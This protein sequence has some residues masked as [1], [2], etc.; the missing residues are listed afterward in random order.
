[1]VIRRRARLALAAGALAFSG[2]G[3]GDAPFGPTGPAATLSIAAEFA[4]GSAE[5]AL[6]A[7]QV[8]R[9][10]VLFVRSDQHVAVDETVNWPGDALTL[11]LGP[12]RLPLRAESDQF[13]VTVTGYLGTQAAFIFGPQTVTVS[14][15]QTTSVDALL[16]YV[17]VSFGE[18]AV[19]VTGAMQLSARWFGA[20]LTVQHLDQAAWDYSWIVG[21]SQAA[22]PFLVVSVP[23]HF[24]AGSYA[25]TT[26]DLLRIYG[27]DDSVY[28]EAP[29][30][31]LIV[32]AFEDQS[33]YTEVL[34]VTTG[35]SLTV[36]SVTAPSST[37]PGRV[38]GT[39]SMQA[40]RYSVRYA[41]EGG[42]D[43]TQ[44]T[45][46]IS[47]AGAFDLPFDFEVEGTSSATVT[48]GPFPGTYRGGGYVG[49]YIG[50]TV[51]YTWGYDGQNAELFTHFMIA[52]TTPGAY[53]IPDRVELRIS[54]WDATTDAYGDA[55]GGTLELLELVPPPSETEHGRVRGSFTAQVPTWVW[56]GSDYVD[57]GTAQVSMAFHLPFWSSGGGAPSERASAEPAAGGPVTGHPLTSPFSAR[58]LPLR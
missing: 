14:A 53:A 50:E 39:L 56:S 4:A 48:G 15:G 55:T 45:E 32:D 27:G 34:Y 43:V 42:T 30:A 31:A 46:T 37:Q 5:A 11:D 8:D 10:R 47:L 1:M 29:F 33:G 7:Q 26:P 40:R 44:H 17:G 12:Y 21:F 9:V 19:E 36:T 41:Y 16:Q 49:S 52:G 24:Q 3:C 6:A 54:Y 51:I 35:G 23:G 20:G 57:G 22:Y 2:H 13:T 28:A 18:F 58:V 38:Q 25:F